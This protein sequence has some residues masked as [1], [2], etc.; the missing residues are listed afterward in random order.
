M[1]RTLGK[2]VGQTYINPTGLLTT[3]EKSPKLSLQLWR[4]EF[5]L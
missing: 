5:N 2:K 4:S 3:G 1:L